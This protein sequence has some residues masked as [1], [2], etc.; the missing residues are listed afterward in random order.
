MDSIGVLCSPI[1][2]TPGK[3]F[4]LNLW[5]TQTHPRQSDVIAVA[6][7]DVTKEYWGGFTVPINQMMG[8]VSGVFHLKV[9]R[10]AREGG[11]GE[12]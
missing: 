5:Y 11:E 1:Q 6:L 2:V 4:T 7:N 10:G 8:H 12:G 9:G 3:D